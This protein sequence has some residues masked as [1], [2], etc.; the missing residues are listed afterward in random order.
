[1][2]KTVNND[3]D[4]HPTDLEIARLVLVSKLLGSWLVCPH[5]TAE[6][7]CACLSYF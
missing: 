5:Q 6:G 4:L 7:F 3:E 2:V 1:M